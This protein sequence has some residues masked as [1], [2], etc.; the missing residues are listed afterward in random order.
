MIGW[1]KAHDEPIINIFKTSSEIRMFRPLCKERPKQKSRL[2]LRE[3]PSQSDEIIR[4][5][6]LQRTNQISQRH[7][8]PITSVH[9]HHLTIYVLFDEAA[10]STHN[11][12]QIISVTPAD[13]KLSGRHVTIIEQSDWTALFNLFHAYHICWH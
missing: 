8:Q 4:F 10:S 3:P 12:Y 5:T 9:L 7:I 13:N 11:G 6:V 1:W 2:L